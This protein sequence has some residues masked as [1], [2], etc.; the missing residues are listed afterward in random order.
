MHS[1]LK[2]LCTNFHANAASYKES[3]GWEEEDIYKDSVQELKTRDNG[4]QALQ[5]SGDYK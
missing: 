5:E 1:L 3:K 4:E 2:N